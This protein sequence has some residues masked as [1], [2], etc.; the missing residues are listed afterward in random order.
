[1]RRLGCSGLEAA[2]GLCGLVLVAPSPP[3]PTVLS[4]EQRESLLHAY[5]SSESIAF[6]RDDVLTALPLSD[7]R[8]IQVIEDSLRGAPQARRARPT[9][10]MLED[11]R[12]DVANI[13]VP[14][15]VLS[16]DHDQVDTTETLRREVLPRIAGARLEVLPGAGHLSMLESP[17]AIARAIASFIA[18]LP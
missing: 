18:T 6:V 1:M 3:S 16:G 5:D 2:E 14:T 15:L 10:I 4:E 7:A 12:S 9:E 17:E 13:N 11:I 8:K